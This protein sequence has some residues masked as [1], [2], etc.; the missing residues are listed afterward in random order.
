MISWRQ[1]ALS[2][3]VFHVTAGG[4]GDVV[5]LLLQPIQQRV[6]RPGERGREGE[7]GCGEGEGGRE[8][9]EGVERGR[10]EGDGVEG[11]RVWRVSKETVY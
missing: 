5:P 2:M 11:G 3:Q 8:G 6:F 10:E 1:H 4:V 7:G 9:V